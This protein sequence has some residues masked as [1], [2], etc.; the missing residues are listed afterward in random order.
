MTSL[1]QTGGGE[2][3]GEIYMS[4]TNIKNRYVYQKK[5]S[6]ERRARERETRRGAS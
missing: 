4:I 2:E 6:D 1:R 5:T 3:G